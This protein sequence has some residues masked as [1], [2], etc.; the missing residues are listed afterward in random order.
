[1]A[2]SKRTFLSSTSALPSSTRSF[3]YSQ[4]LP[5]ST[6]WFA[7][8]NLAMVLLIFVLAHLATWQHLHIWDRPKAWPMMGLCVAGYLVALGV[9]LQWRRFHRDSGY[10]FTVV[11]TTAVFL[12]IIGIISMTRT[13]YSRTYLAVF[14]GATLFWGL[15]VQTLNHRRMQT[16]ALIP[17][18][19]TDRLQALGGPGGWVPLSEPGLDHPV[20]GV[21]ADFHYELSDAW[22]RFVSRCHVQ[23]IPVFNAASVYEF[24]TGK[25]NLDHLSEDL[26]EGFTLSRVYLWLRRIIE[27]MAVFVVLPVILPLMGGVALAIWLESGRPILFTQT[28]VGQGGE[29]FEMLKFRSMQRR[30]DEEGPKFASESDQRVTRVGSF[31][32]QYRLD[33]LPQLWN[34][35]KGEMS[36]IGPRPEQ[37]PFAEAFEEEIPFYPYRHM[38]RPGIT[39]W[40]QVNQGYVADTDRTYEKLAYDLYYL[41]HFSPGLDM[42]IVYRTLRIILTGFGAR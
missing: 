14:F 11:S 30:A 21:V 3:S 34:V 38:V 24:Y 25:V 13:F 8:L 33:E 42:L 5:P 29:L 39:G 22:A 26:V 17:G 35:L 40:A 6:A 31:I 12:V 32:R 37:V 36:I 15:A 20:D 27:L 1:M 19:M 9:S 4:S 10:L 18:E 23:G 28:R 16:L 2:N 7:F 41:K